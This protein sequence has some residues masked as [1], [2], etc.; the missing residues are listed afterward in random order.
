MRRR[1]GP[2][3]RA[4]DKTHA[5]PHL[6][7]PLPPGATLPY[8]LSPLPFVPRRGILNGPATGLA[9]AELIADG[10][11]RSVDIAPFDPARGGHEFGAV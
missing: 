2:H 4:P 6:P 8:V 5:L 11:V 3:H 10:A 7:P 1:C 9:L